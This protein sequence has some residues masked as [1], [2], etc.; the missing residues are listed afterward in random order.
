MAVEV[1][2]WGEGEQVGTFIALQNGQV[3]LPSKF[4][5]LNH[6]FA[7]LSTLVRD[8]SFGNGQQLIRRLVKALSAGDERSRL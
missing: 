8:A 3:K 1:V 4:L 2:S 6:R 7:L 5:C